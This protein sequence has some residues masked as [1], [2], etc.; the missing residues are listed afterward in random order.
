MTTKQVVYGQFEDPSHTYL[1][2]NASVPDTIRVFA[3]IDRGA[4]M[5]CTISNL[6]IRPITAWN[7]RWYSNLPDWKQRFEAEAVRVYRQSHTRR[8][9]VCGG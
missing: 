8:Y 6:S 2:T 3:G 4:E 5:V 7:A 1:V 9:R